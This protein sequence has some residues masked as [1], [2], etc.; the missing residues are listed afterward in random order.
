ML[1]I[2]IPPCVSVQTHVGWHT[3]LN[4][5]VVT[6][7]TTMMPTTTVTVHLG[8]TVRDRFAR[9]STSNF[10]IVCSI[11]VGIRLD[12]LIVRYGFPLP[13][14]LN[15]RCQFMHMFILMN[16]GVREL[17][18]SIG[19]VRGKLENIAVVAAISFKCPGV[20]VSV[21]AHFEPWRTSSRSARHA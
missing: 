2:H 4:F 19:S 16:A 18:D 21:T 13:F 6:M 8:S 5:T 9:S 14:P 10:C 11:C 20:R 1:V 12:G 17:S 7:T 15:L 3:R